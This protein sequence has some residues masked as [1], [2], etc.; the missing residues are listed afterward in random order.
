VKLKIKGLR[1]QCDSKPQLLGFEA[2]E[3]LRNRMRKENYR[4]RL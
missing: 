2:T 4:K 3:N 1:P